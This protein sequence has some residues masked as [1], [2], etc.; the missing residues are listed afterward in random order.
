MSQQKRKLGY[1]SVE[2]AHGDNEFFDRDLFVG[3]MKYLSDLD[4]QSRLQRDSKNN[5][6]IAV[7]R[8]WETE[9]QGATTYE[10]RFKSCKYYHSPDYM[11]STDGSERPTEKQLYEGDKEVTHICMRID[12]LEVMC[13]VEERRS[14]VTFGAVIRYLNDKLRVYLRQE[15]RD[16]GIILVGSIVPPQDFLEALDATER[17]TIAE[18][19]VDK[20][21]MGTGYLGMLEIDAST[22]EEVVMTVKSKPKQSLAKRAAKEAFL[23]IATEGTRV[24]RI[25]LRGRDYNNMSVIIDSLNAKKKDEV[26]V[27]LMPNGIVNTSSIF[28]KMEEALEV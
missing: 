25:R 11:S 19:F 10:V 15:N 9:I 17:I 27:E 12:T 21:V 26:F 13:V 20:E 4:V 1:W 18:L 7:D 6:A 24:R 22:R 23:G 2:F 3:F 28:L 8:I 14:G 16:E 5:K